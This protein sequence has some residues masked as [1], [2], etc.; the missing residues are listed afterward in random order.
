MTK[1]KA[2]WNLSPTD[3]LAIRTAAGD[4]S[5]WGDLSKHVRSNLVR[6][7]T[8]ATRD[9]NLGEELAQNY[10]ADAPKRLRR[11]RGEGPAR[12]YMGKSVRFDAWST[13]RRHSREQLLD[14]DGA[15]TLEK[16][17]ANEP[18]PEDTT[19]RRSLNVRRADALVK[20]IGELGDKHRET[21][22]LRYVKQMKY[23]EIA[24]VLGIPVGTVMSRLNKI[25]RQL[26]QR[27]AE[28]D[29]DVVRRD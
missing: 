20:A 25:K 22:R 16:L 18:G 19:I 21:A 29:P 28:L 7:G 23:N 15:V 6:I 12:A 10:L 26:G 4:K 9:S 17:P 2:P 3:H 8:S 11:Y 13:R 1:P 14:P 24:E 27:L 5:A